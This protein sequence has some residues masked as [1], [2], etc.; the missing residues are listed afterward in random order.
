M[1]RNGD[2]MLHGREGLGGVYEAL[3][4]D[5]RH[6]VLSLPDVRRASIDREG[7][8]REICPDWTSSN[9]DLDLSTCEVGVGESVGT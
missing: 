7:C 3:V 9:E 5:R 8:F 1:V 2:A 4:S 6:W